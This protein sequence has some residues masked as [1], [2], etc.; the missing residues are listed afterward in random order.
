VPE[1]PDVHVDLASPSAF[2]AGP[3]LIRGADRGRARS[4][5]ALR[6]SEAGA[7]EDHDQCAD[8]IA[9]EV[10][11]GV[12]HDGDD[13]FRARRVGRVA[14]PLV[15]VGCD[16]GGSRACSRVSDGVRQSPAG[17]LRPSRSS[18]PISGRSSATTTDR[19]HLPTRFPHQR[20]GAIGPRYAS[21]CLAVDVSQRAAPCAAGRLEASWCSSTS[22]SRSRRVRSVRWF[23]RR[24]LSSRRLATVD[25]LG[26]VAVGGFAR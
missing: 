7:P 25:P 22:A 26:S 19:E 4:A 2:A 5:T 12:A 17:E 10:L 13:L 8:A 20:H 24:T 18:G 11:A 9:M 21:V 15:S 23:E 3:E 1:V 6:G 16:R 14:L